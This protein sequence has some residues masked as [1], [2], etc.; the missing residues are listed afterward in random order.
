VSGIGYDRS[1]SPLWSGMSTLCTN[2]ASPSGPRADVQDRHVRVAHTL[3]QRSAY[4]Q[5]LEPKWTCDG[6][7]SSARS[8]NLRRGSRRR[9]AFGRRRARAV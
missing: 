9:P 4:R 5:R 8:M 3:S 1:R 2:V 7:S 6:A